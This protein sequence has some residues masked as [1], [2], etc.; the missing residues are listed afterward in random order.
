MSVSPVANRTPLVQ[1]HFPVGSEDG[2]VCSLA[3]GEF[4]F[5]PGDPRTQLYIIEPGMRF[6]FSGNVIGL[7]YL[8]KHICAAKALSKSRFRSLPL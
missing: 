2:P 4:L 8:D 1:E 3:A 6:S 7:G 5:R